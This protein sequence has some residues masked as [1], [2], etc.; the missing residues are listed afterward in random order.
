MDSHD[1]TALPVDELR[2]GGRGHYLHLR[3]GGFLSSQSA[4]EMTFGDRGNSISRGAPG[5]GDAKWHK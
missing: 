2:Y 5:F 3:L 1:P 4:G